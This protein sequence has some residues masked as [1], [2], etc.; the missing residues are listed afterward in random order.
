M[1]AVESSLFINIYIAHCLVNV[2]WLPRLLY[3]YVFNNGTSVCD[4]EDIDMI[5]SFNIVRMFIIMR[6]FV[7]TVGILIYFFVI[8]HFVDVC[9]LFI[10]HEL[11]Q[12]KKSFRNTFRVSNGLDPFQ[13]LGP[14]LGLNCLQGLSADDESRR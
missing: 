14:D 11:F 2:S 9:R 8:F 1:R 13:D 10:Q 5:I 4:A 6:L 3:K 12:Q 7:I